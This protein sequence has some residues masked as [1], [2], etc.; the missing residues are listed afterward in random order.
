MNEILEFGSKL[1]QVREAK[2]ISLDDVQA[3]TKIPIDIL[4]S[5]EQGETI[6][7][8]S[9]IYIKGFLKIYAKFLGVELSDEKKTYTPYPSAQTDKKK[10]EFRDI[11]LSSEKRIDY[12][13]LFKMIIGFV[14]VIALINFVPK[15]I[16]KRKSITRADRASRLVVSKPASAM[17]VA[18]PSQIKLSVRA[19]ENTWLNVKRDGK[20]VFR[21]VLRKGTVDSWVAKEKFEISVANASTIELEVNNKIIPPLGKKGQAL[22]N[23]TITKD[24]LSADK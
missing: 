17:Q 13:L 11:K 20:V 14:A 9:P 6:R 3:A 19:K 2:G 16:H 24:G 8:L 12:F 4:R 15:L 18:K 5:I 23:I 21:Q 10:S 7:K 1:K 22:K